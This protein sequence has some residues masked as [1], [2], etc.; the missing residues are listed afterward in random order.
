VFD[1]VFNSLRAFNMLGIAVGGLLLLGIAL[2]IVGDFARWRLRAQRHEGTI[3]G[4]RVQAGGGKSRGERYSPVIEYTNSQG[5]RIAAE[6]DSSSSLLADKIP[7]RKVTILVLPRDPE[8]ARVI[9]YTWVVIGLLMGIPGI[10]LIAIA[11]RGLEFDGYTLLVGLLLAAYFFRKLRKVIKPRGERESAGRF[12]V[13][14]RMSRR[15]KRDAMPLWGKAEVLA[16]LRER[17]RVNRKWMP[18]VAIAGCL[19]AGLGLY[20]ALG[21][22]Q[23]LAGSAAAEGRVVALHSEFD[24]SGDGS[25]HTY[26][27][28]VAFTLPD[29]SAVRFRGRTGS[30]PPTYRKGDRVRV[31]YLP[32]TP[33]SAM[34][35][36]GVLNW[37]PAAGCMALGALFAWLGAK[38]WLGIRRRGLTTPPA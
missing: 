34:I 15:K 24:P 38:G 32:Q 26:Y 14:T 7:G 20:M 16:R 37:L 35:D 23:R 18:G 25:S 5:Q 10:V 4:V 8:T 11:F 12:R 17:D 3:V 27:P 28:E 9:G 29:G 13:R 36:H 6:S 21:M 33:A 1:L 30:N 2:V 31:L 19:L 22:Q